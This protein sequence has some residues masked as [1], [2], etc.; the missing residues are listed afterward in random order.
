[1][2]TPLN[3][4]TRP[5]RNERLPA[6]AFGF[7]AS[8]LVVATVIHGLGVARLA[9][10]SATS[11]DDEVARLTIER[12]SLREKDRVLRA[13]R[14]DKATADRWTAL[15]GLVDL[16]SFSWTGLLFGLEA[17]LPKD[18][19]LKAIT[20]EFRKGRFFLT[21]EAVARNAEDAVPLV[22]TLED[23]PEFADVFLA[24]IGEGSTDVLCRYEMTYWPE[25]APPVAPPG[26]AVA[27]AGSPEVGP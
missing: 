14:V 24:Q 17:T 4:A 3:L 11:L 22:K 23:R 1:V 7:A 9:S 20:P 16:R 10:A 25:A 13:V 2:R 18:I 26:P 8:L 19:R 5:A 27:S 15:K 12:S 6:L 21:L